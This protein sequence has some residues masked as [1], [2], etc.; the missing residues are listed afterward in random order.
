M[1]ITQSRN[2]YCLILIAVFCTMTAA[3]M[4]GAS[5]TKIAVVVSQKIRPY[6][7][8][9]DGI[10]DQVSQ[11]TSDAKISDLKTSN[12]KTSDAIISGADVFFLSP[13]DDLVTAQVIDRLITGAV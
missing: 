12:L 8:V 7:Q 6:L 10:L 4:V 3:P 2:L 5:D 13:G 9:T 1:P 11:K